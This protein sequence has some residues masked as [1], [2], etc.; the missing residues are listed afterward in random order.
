MAQMTDVLSRGNAD[1]GDAIDPGIK[2]LIDNLIVPYMVEEFLR[3]HGPA[4][5]TKSND[6]PNI[7]T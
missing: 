2:D 4:A 7:A 1:G 3:L 5:L 6:N